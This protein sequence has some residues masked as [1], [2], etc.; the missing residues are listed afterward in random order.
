MLWKE[1]QNIPRLE[2]LSFD[3]QK[4]PWNINLAKTFSS[5]LRDFIIL[6]DFINYKKLVDP[7]PR[8]HKKTKTKIKTLLLHKTTR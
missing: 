6:K 4:I 7:P 1:F 3:S 5:T 2:E 8:P